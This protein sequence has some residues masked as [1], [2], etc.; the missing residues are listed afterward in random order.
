MMT[1]I[2]K[3]LLPVA[4][5]LFAA[6]IAALAANTVFFTNSGD[7]TFP[8]SPPLANGSAGAIDNMVIGAGTKRAATFTTVT[9]DTYAGAGLTANFASPPPIGSTVPN[10]GVFTTLQATSIGGVTPGTGAFT[11]AS[12][13]GL[14]S[15]QSTQVDTGTKTATASGGA[16]TL[17]KNAGVITSEALTTAGLA[18]Y[19]LTLTDSAIAA[20][21][22]LMVSVANGTNTQGTVAVGPVKPGSG[23]AT[24]VIHN[25]HATQALNGTLVISFV[26]FKN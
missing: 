12:T 4:G 25:L 7:L 23:T 11:T 21:D 1:K 17:N 3:L 8:F 13:S 22:Q 26:V 15:L 6:S 9:A 10:T 5:A 24:I 16:A 20:A 14:A 2:R 18:D 19:T